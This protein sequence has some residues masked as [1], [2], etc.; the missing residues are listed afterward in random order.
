VSSLTD[1]A[2][3][4][5]RSLFSP[6]AARE[7]LPQPSPEKPIADHLFVSNVR[8]LSMAAVVFVHCLAKLLPL[9]G[10][11]DMGLPARI[12]RQ[13]AEFDVIGFF[14]ISGFLMEESLV[15]RNPLEYLSRRLQRILFPWLAWFSLYCLILL[16]NNAVTSNVRIDSLSRSIH[17]A[18]KVVVDALYSPYWFVPNLLLSMCVFL[19]CRR[20]LFDLHMGAVLLLISLFYGLNIYLHWIPVDNHTE[21]WFGFI[22]YL[23]LGALAARNFHALQA[24]IARIPTLAWMAMAVLTGLAAL[25]ESGIQVAAGSPMPM[26]VLRISNQAYSIVIVLMVFK[27]R[28]PAWPRAMNVR[29]NTF[30][31]YLSHIIILWIFNRIL[32]SLIH[33]APVR[34]HW[35]LQAAIRVCSVLAVFVLVYGSAFL[36]TQWLLT[37][38][39]LRWAVGS[40]APK[41]KTSGQSSHLSK[42]LP[43][44]PGED[45]VPPPLQ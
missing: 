4:E 5:S 1:H 8:F 12:L 25:K 10:I 34:Q 22:F 38:S 13:S 42:G 3:A 2:Q 43:R 45:S 33:I 11:Y 23:W 7:T 18:L 28:R 36:L 31:I 44:T 9:A 30:G 39:R 19:A 32:R 16:T 26:N 20:Y 29:T 35:S 37:R 41:S 27:L 40:F 6:L 21:A 24:G 15:R 14:L 17:L